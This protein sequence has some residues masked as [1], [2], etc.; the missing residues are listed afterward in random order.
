MWGSASDHNWHPLLQS[1]W[2]M[3]AIMHPSPQSTSSHHVRDWHSSV[4]G[5]CQA[6][7]QCA[8]PTPVKLTTKGNGSEIMP[9]VDSGLV[10]TQCQ[11]SRTSLGWINGKLWLLL[12]TSTETSTEDRWRLQVKCGGS[13]CLQDCVHLG[14]GVDISSPS[15]PL[16]SDWMIAM[17]THRTESWL[18]DHRGYVTGKCPPVSRFSTT[19]H[20][21][22]WHRMLPLIW[23]R[24]L[25]ASWRVASYPCFPK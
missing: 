20:H 4:C 5:I 8:S 18:Q 7:D 21:L 1:D 19:Y 6:Q 9:W 13:G 23:R 10:I 24:K 17:T 15:M 11:T 16:Y 12:W 25:A 3:W 22:P 2:P 14:E